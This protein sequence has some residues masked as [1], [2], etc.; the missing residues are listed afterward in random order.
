LGRSEYKKTDIWVHAVSVGEVI[1]ALPFLRSLKKEFPEA[2]ITLSTITY[3]GQK[4]AREEFPEADRIMYMPWDTGLCIRKA[5]RSLS[6]RV[7]I[8]VET[9]LW[10]MLF[11]TLKNAGSKVLLLNGRLSQKSFKG[12]RLIRPFMRKAL[13]NVDYFYM[14]GHGDAERIRALGAKPGLVGFMGN[15]KFDAFS[16]KTAEP[17]AWA[18]LIEGRVLVAGSTHKGEEEIIL[19]AYKKIKK[20]FSD[21]RLII[22]PRHPERF[23]EVEDILKKGKFDFIRRS[24]I[25]SESVVPVNPDKPGRGAPKGRDFRF[26][27][28]GSGQLSV[29]TTRRSGDSYRVATDNKQQTTDCKVPDIILLDT[30]GELSRLYSRADVAFIGGSLQP[31]GGHNIL[32]PAFWSKPIIIGPH[33]DNFPIASVFVESGA[34]YVVKD[35]GEFAE[36]VERLLGNSEKARQAGL[37]A[38]SIVDNNTGS[39]EKA[40][41]LVRSYLPKT[42]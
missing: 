13:S 30:I 33:M 23:K 11:M 38:R 15:F 29:E 35:P 20:D 26:A 22:A 14:Q 41:G 37:T 28:T 25:K 17:L 16:H 36:A 6:P 32:E 34:A 12:Y 10:P 7:F 8:T 42:Q 24:E 1:A 31:F 39:V 5:V 3:T 9:E 4:I 21:L 27:T 18:N 40:L 19:D 2:K